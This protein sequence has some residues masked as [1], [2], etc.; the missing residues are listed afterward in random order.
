[1]RSPFVTIAIACRD[2]EAR[3]RSLIEAALAQDWPHD[4]LEVLVADGMSMD[5]TREVLAQL[6]A[7]DRRITLLDNPQRTRAAG[8]NECIRRAK[9]AVVVRLDPGGQYP[10][11]FVR[12]CAEA[13]ERTGADAV[14]GT[15][16]PVGRTFLQRCVAAALRSPL[17]G[18]WGK[19]EQANPGWA[20]G[21]RPGAFRR[22][23]FERVGLFDPRAAADEDRE[24]ARRI[25][26]AG[27]HAE[28]SD[29]LGADY[30]PGATVR[31]LAERSLS[32]GMARARTLLKHGRFS[33][34]GP[35]L[36]LLWLAGELALLAAS[37]RK[38]LPWT[39]AAYA[40]AT[41]AEAVRVA[42]KDGALAVPV[43]W[44]LFPVL[45][46]AHGIGF[47]GGLARYVVR[48]DWDTP[49]RIASIEGDSV[50]AGA[51]A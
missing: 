2:D 1:M 49:E 27:G 17:G 42:S 40:L 43:V 18:G 3:I 8:L 5:A 10:P 45:H 29:E 11:D 24:L 14:E 28:R 39:L 30:Y 36:P 32:Y 19:G 47:A 31:G 35:N 20:D 16:R 21:V 4:A 6:A 46:V 25:A 13:L 9:G 12:R 50:A 33:S 38:A 44:A 15:A 22:G 7:A 41:G 23:V 34:W 26:A 37:P 51:T 48:P